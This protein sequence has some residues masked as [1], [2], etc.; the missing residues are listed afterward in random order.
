MLYSSD[1]IVETIGSYPAVQ[2]ERIS[3]VLLKDDMILP[4]RIFHSLRE[5]SRL[6]GHAV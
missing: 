4:S 3:I 6:S 5:V 2:D 1:F